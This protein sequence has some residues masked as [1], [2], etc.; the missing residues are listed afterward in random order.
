MHSTSSIVKL[1]F[2][3]TVVYYEQFIEVY[4]TQGEEGLMFGALMWIE[5]YME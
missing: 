1:I 5:P 4:L 3:H 2:V